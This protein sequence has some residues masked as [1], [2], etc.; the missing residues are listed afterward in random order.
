M[1]ATGFT[2]GSLNPG[3]FNAITTVAS[4]ANKLSR[5]ARS[6]GPDVVARSFEGT[7]WIYYTAPFV[8]ALLATAIYLLLKV[9]QYETA[10]EGQDGDD[11]HLVMRNKDGE[12]TGMVD[13]VRGNEAQEVLAGPAKDT[14]EKA[15]MHP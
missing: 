9:A 10:V 3:E 7:A 5:P 11:T 15:P 13:E 8:G 14:N 4:S 2:G 6:L 1:F 12:V